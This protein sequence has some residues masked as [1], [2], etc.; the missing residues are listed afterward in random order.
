MH[1]DALKY[2]KKS[3][4]VNPIYV[5]A[6]NGISTIMQMK[7][8]IEKSKIYSTKAI[9]LNPNSLLAQRLIAN[10]EITNLKNFNKAIKE[11]YKALNINNKNYEFVNKSISVTKLKH[12][13]EQATYYIKKNY[14]DKIIID[15]VKIGNKIL[16]RKENLIDIKNINKNIQLKSY[17]IKILS[18][19]LKKNY[20]YKPNKNIKYFLNP[21]NKWKEIE[22]RYLYKNKQIIYIDNFLSP[23]TIYELQ[24][25]CLLSKV[26]NS[27][28]KN[29]YL[30][31][32]ADRGFISK[33]HLKIA[34]DLK[35]KM[36][37]I[38]G[39]KKL[40]TFWAYKYEPKI[41]KG[42]N[43]HA[44]SARSNLNFW[45]T[46]DKYNNNKKN[47][48]LRIYDVPAPKKWPFAR[49]NR[50]VHDIR[51]FLK[52]KGANFFDIPYKYNRAVLFNSEYFHNTQKINFK[53]KYEG[54]RI[55]ITYLFGDRSFYVP[56]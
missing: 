15:F 50:N 4:K 25:F 3:I 17:E 33:I 32:S 30:G 31:A 49:Y 28:H 34:L 52:N 26:W 54:R 10:A 27:E 40:Q 13:V 5:N 24:N 48:G 8:E 44:D 45:I 16:K 1:K 47:G 51:K 19:Y 39:R 18:A 43:I 46:P 7:K 14:K 20:L 11:S 38:F 41:S 37:K 22:D 36:P 2:F 23:E 6:Y 42:I 29:K 9:K 35:K 56:S 53:N 55:N 21:K 12:D